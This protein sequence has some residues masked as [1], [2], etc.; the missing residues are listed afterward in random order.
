MTVSTKEQSPWQATPRRGAARHWL[1]RVVV[2]VGVA[3]LVL[4][5][6]LAGRFTSGP[7]S[8]VVFDNVAVVAVNAESPIVCVD[9]G[10]SNGLCGWLA[11]ANPKPRVG[12]SVSVIFHDMD[13]N[14]LGVLQIQSR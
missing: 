8:G 3:V 6:F 4:M 10:S 5:G 14:G 9:D 2:A 13:I 12:D 11:S 7:H 1:V